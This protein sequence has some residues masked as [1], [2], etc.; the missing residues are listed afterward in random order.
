MKNVFLYLSALLVL[1]ACDSN[2]PDYVL[3]ETA[4]CSGLNTEAENVVCKD[5]DDKTIY[6]RIVEYFPNGKIYRD[7]YV[8]DGVLHG[9]YEMFYE[10]GKK[11]KYIP[12]VN[13]RFEGLARQWYENGNIQSEHNYKNGKMYGLRK[14]YYDTGIL[15]DEMNY[16]NAKLEG[17]WKHYTKEGKLD[18][19]NNYKDG[20]VERGKTYSK[21][22]KSYTEYEDK[23]NAD[24]DNL[25]TQY[26]YNEYGILVSK[27]TFT[28]FKKT[29]HEDI[30]SELIQEQCA[31]YIDICMGDSLSK[32]KPG[33]K[34][35]ISQSQIVSK[36]TL[37]IQ[38]ESMPN[39]VI[40]T[41][42]KYKIGD[43]YT[44]SGYI[45]YTGLQTY[46]ALNSLTTQIDVYEF[47]ET[48]IP[49]CK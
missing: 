30:D 26:E 1:S 4:F 27:S 36:N 39:V 31:K 19:E 28:N 48:N 42:R 22:G 15:R 8:K 24:G 25:Q 6:G 38:L 7:F 3:N 32:L 34:T 5:K 14:E 13:G 21:N 37:G 2:K 20:K 43:M 16:K 12:H 11:H 46:R 29:S 41:N 33:C 23:K 47:K 9:A 49:V 17:I 35:E 40:K 45:E 18:Y 44:P 10:N